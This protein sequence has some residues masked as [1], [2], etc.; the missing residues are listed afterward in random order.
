LPLLREIRGYRPK[1]HNI[2][3]A[4]AVCGRPFVGKVDISKFHPSITPSHVSWALKEHG[5][6]S[7]WSREI[8]LIVTYKGSVPQGAPTSNHI[9]NLVMDSVLRREVKSFADGRHVQFVNFGDD[10]AFY[11]DDA[12]AVK[13]TTAFAKK[14]IESFGFR[15]NEKCRECEHRGS[16]RSFIGCATGR[17]APDITRTQYREFRS[18]LRTKIESERTRGNDA[19]ITSNSELNSIMH[20]I[21]YVKRLNKHKA[22]RLLDDFYRLCAAR[23]DTQCGLRAS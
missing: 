12:R 1:S 21:A 19:P 14:S 13:I 23:R 22:R 9:A 4:S 7:S 16:G 18:E 3:A 20:R 2:N 11:G 10:V 15:T 6:S 5:L 17:K 8:A